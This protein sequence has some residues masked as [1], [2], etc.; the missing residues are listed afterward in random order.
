M[1]L[2]LL[3]QTAADGS[4]AGGLGLTLE[5]TC[6]LLLSHTGVLYPPI[7]GCTGRQLAFFRPV[8]NSQSSFQV[9]SF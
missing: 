9:V 8:V 6:C 2:S 1:F 7:D 4:G 5:I 3:S